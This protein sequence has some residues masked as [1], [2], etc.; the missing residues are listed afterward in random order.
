MASW[1][2]DTDTE[3]LVWAVSVDDERRLTRIFMRRRVNLRTRQDEECGRDEQ[4]GSKRG[5]QAS[6]DTSR[7]SIPGGH[8]KEEREV[9]RKVRGLG[10]GKTSNSS[11]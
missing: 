10:N 5:G 9:V 1:A 6:G 2:P 8:G 3:W 7:K 11:H 4:Y